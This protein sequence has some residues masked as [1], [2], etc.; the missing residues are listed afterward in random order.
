MWPSLKDLLSLSVW[1]SLMQVR[2]VR[3]FVGMIVS[4]AVV[5]AKEIEWIANRQYC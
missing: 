1:T 3:H 5:E 2:A 4:A